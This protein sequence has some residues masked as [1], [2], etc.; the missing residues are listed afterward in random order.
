MNKTPNAHFAIKTWNEQPYGGDQALP[1]LLEEVMTT[2]TG[3]IEG[4]GQVENLMLYH[5]DGSATIVGLERII[6]RI[7]DK[8]CLTMG[9]GGA[10]RYTG[11]QRDSGNGR[12]SS[13]HHLC[14]P[15]HCGGR[16]TDHTRNS[17]DR[18]WQLPDH[19]HLR[20]VCGEQCRH[21]QCR[22]PRTVRTALVD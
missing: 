9:I 13:A 12:W 4:E 10:D 20:D 17:G 5:S 16:F 8:S 1:E 22:A 19:R 15:S 7:G 14:Q 6:G 18:R 2:Y 21:V 3:D 11:R